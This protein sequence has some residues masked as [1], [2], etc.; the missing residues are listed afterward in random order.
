[1]SNAAIV[2]RHR[3][4]PAPSP[5]AA[6]VTEAEA[7]QGT[8]TNPASGRGPWRTAASL[9][10]SLTLVVSFA[11]FLFLAVGPHVLGYRTSTMLTGSMAP[12]IMPGDVVVTAER[13]ATD[14]RVGDVISYQIPIEDHRVETHRVTEV[15][16]AKD[17][18]ISIRTKGD[19]NSNVDPWTAILAEDTVW[20]VQTVVPELGHVIQT[21]RAP[22]VHDVVK[23]VALA[24]L[25]LLGLT[26]IWGRDDDEQ[27]E[28]D[29]SAD[30]DEPVRA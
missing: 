5:T 24:G 2:G 11:A 1:M 18:T 27:P 16:T 21:L 30:D 9:V 29:G 28:D 7:G 4:A 13:P 20:E 3:A 25:L 15:I 14:V 26:T 23:W 10:L 6:D 22:I 17:G 12:G 8:G 19:A